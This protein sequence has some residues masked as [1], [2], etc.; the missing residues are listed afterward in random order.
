MQT[1]SKG[2]SWADVLLD[3]PP[4]PFPAAIKLDSV[5][6]ICNALRRHAA[7]TDPSVQFQRD[8]I[9]RPDRDAASRLIETIRLKI[10]EAVMDAYSVWRPLSV[11][12]MVPARISSTAASTLL[13]QATIP[14]VS[15]RPE[16]PWKWNDSSQL[17]FHY[18][19]SCNS[20][21]STFFLT[22][23]YLRML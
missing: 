4:Y 20:V 13:P 14:P 21:V 19:K 5:P 18:L 2:L 16:A 12:S 22:S 1:P 10:Y 17:C 8:V 7:W 15:L 9:L 23:M 6:P 3:R 11:R